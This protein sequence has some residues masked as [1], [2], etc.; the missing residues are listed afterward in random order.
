[1]T[2]STYLSFLIRMW[3]EEVGNHNVQA[4]EW[5]GEVEH[6]Q[7]GQ[8]LRFYSLSELFDYLREQASQPAELDEGSETQDVD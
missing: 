8:V 7:S 2:A 1:M 3:R 6:I 5:R 4:P